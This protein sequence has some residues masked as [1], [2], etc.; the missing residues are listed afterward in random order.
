MSIQKPYELHSWIATWNNPQDHCDTFANFDYKT[1]SP[2]QFVHFQLAIINMFVNASRTARKPDTS[3]IYVGCEVGENGTFHT[4]MF[5]QAKRKIEFE[6]LQ[7]IYPGI[8]LEPTYG[9]PEQAID[10]IYK[11]GTLSNEEKA[12]TLLCEPVH[13]GD[14]TYEQSE[15]SQSKSKIFDE[16]ES[17][18][19]DGM[20]P[21]DI[22]A[23][24]PKLAFYANAIERTYTARKNAS[25]PTI[26]E[27]TIYYHVGASGTG[28]TYTLL[29]LEDQYGKGSIYK[30]P[31]SWKN[32]WDTYN[33][34][35]VVI[36]DEARGDC[37]RYSELLGYLDSYKIILPCRY[38]DK[39]AD[40][41][42]VHITTIEP[43]E[44]LYDWDN[45]EV[46][47]NYDGKEQLYRRIDYIVYHWMD[48]Q[49][50]YK[51]FQM[52]FSQYENYRQLVNEAK[53]QDPTAGS[54]DKNYYNPFIQDTN[55]RAEATITT[56]PTPT[57]TETKTTSSPRL[58]TFDYIQYSGEIMNLEPAPQEFEY[59]PFIQYN[60]GSG[61]Y[62]PTEFDCLAF[63]EAMN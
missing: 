61:N 15:A 51:Q 49:G 33:F 36:F 34:E 62:M 43:P 60:Y 42:E 19:E 6:S 37:I 50:N 39:Y 59:N 7:K 1:A 40:Y 53:K 55:K 47:S 16:I 63:L 18:L 24:S 52:P 57:P 14:Y 3:S 41:N 11:R 13:W 4:H 35:K 23:E 58:E 28:K 29:N 12:E 10:Y 48:E 31:Q 56:K 22:Y 21:Q 5:F 38:A 46:F 2:E 27:R 25:I 30:T 32:I 17:M 44:T 9:T 54:R 20:T 45:P 26:Q 8:H